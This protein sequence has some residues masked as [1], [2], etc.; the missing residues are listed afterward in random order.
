MAD[1]VY[2]LY[3][4]I[5]DIK[6]GNTP[7]SKNNGNTFL[8]SATGLNNG[9]SKAITSVSIPNNKEV[10]MVSSNGAVGDAFYQGRDFFTTGDVNILTPKFKINPYIAM[11]LNTI[12]RQEKFRFNYGRK[13]GKEKMLKH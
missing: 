2:F 4:D 6:K 11:F 7:K 5:F 9:V 8:I 3:E 12:I 1:W 13:W 10:I